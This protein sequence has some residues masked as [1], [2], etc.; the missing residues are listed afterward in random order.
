[1]FGNKKEEKTTHKMT[2]YRVHLNIGA[3]DNVDFVTDIKPKLRYEEGEQI[4]TTCNRYVIIMSDFKSWDG[5]YSIYNKI[6]FDSFD[7]A[8]YETFEAD[9]IDE[10]MEEE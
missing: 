9:V 6:T 5:P 7:V 8:Y 10:K 3:N 1:M 4:I 2:L